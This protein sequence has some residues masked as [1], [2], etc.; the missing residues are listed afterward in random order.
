MS[1]SSRLEKFAELKLKQYLTVLL[2]LYMQRK[3]FEITLTFITLTQTEEFFSALILQ[4]KFF[5][6]SHFTFTDRKV[7]S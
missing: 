7:I 1:L 4:S 3:N 6:L 2:A 5:T